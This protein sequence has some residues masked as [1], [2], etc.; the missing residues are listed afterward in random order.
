MNAEVY[1]RDKAANFSVPAK[2][3]APLLQ[4]LRPAVK[5][6]NPSKWAVLGELVIT[7]HDGKRTRVGLYRTSSGLGAF[8]TE[9]DDSPVSRKQY[10]RGSTDKAIK[11]ALIAAQKDAR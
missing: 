8:S 10:Y 6:W 1:G 4:S 9:P 5:D 2:H 7:T 3:F 11:D